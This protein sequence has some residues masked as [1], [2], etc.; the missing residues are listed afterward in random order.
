MG[1]LGW[2]MG[3]VGVQ[4]EKH[5]E[6]ILNM[7]KGW[8]W[9]SEHET[10]VGIPEDKSG[11]Q[12]GAGLT[13]AQLMYIHENGSPANKIPARPVLQSALSG[14]EASGRIQDY[15]SEGCKHALRGDVNGAQAEWEKAG[16][17][18]VNA[19]MEKFTDGT[20]APSAPSTIAQKGSDTPLIDTGALRQS[21]TYVVRREK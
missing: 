1:L 14:A 3:N 4:I 21:I 18:G 16:M 2:T 13:N 17:V 11:R 9:L 20:L 8:K 6:T 10:L 15:L 12:D 19:A 5:G 7:I